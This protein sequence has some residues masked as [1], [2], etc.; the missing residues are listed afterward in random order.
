MKNIRYFVL[1]CV[2]LGISACGSA[3]PSGGIASQGEAANDE[4]T[5]HDSDESDLNPVADLAFRRWQGSIQ[6]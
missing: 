4:S 6:V 3:L 2:L 5:T 1:L